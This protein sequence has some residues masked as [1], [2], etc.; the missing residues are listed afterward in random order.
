MDR[1]SVRVM[2]KG[3]GWVMP[4]RPT[5]SD[6]G[7]PDEAEQGESVPRIGAG[8]DKYFEDSD[9][10]VNISD[11]SDDDDDDEASNK[12]KKERA[13]RDKTELHAARLNN[14]GIDL[15]HDDD[16]VI[17]RGDGTS[18]TRAE[19]DAAFSKKR[20]DDVTMDKFGMGGYFTREGQ[21]KENE[22]EEEDGQGDAWLQALDEKGALALAQVKTPQVE[23]EET[24]ADPVAGR[25][26]I[27][28][29]LKPRETVLAALRRLGPKKKV[30]AWQLKQNTRQQRKK[31]KQ[32][33]EKDISHQQAK[34]R[35]VHEEEDEAKPSEK[36]ELDEAQKA[37]EAAEVAK[38]KQLFDALTSAAQKLI[39]A[40]HF[41]IYQETRERME[42]MMDREIDRR[43]EAAAARKGR[44]DKAKEQ[45]E[46]QWLY[47]W[48]EED[49]QVHGPFNGT[50]MADW[51]S[52]GYFNKKVV[53]KCVGDQT[54]WLPASSV[55]SFVDRPD[56][57]IGT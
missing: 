22:T 46:I 5:S 38:N 26:A 17:Q 9:D 52:D 53:V 19:I 47:R 11:D 4:K 29:M 25:A 8:L 44:Q 54:P 12:M 13:D 56:T 6:M 20:N 10:E 37:A 41:N 24:E 48:T 36:G 1:K 3:K 42:L 49:R 39:E 2:G 40:G 18:R 43:E 7:D 57:S 51:A 28:R 27:M 55:E 23:A 16:V 31:K 30:P 45:G 32:K 15:N 35:R 33:E 34:R 14:Q 21:F 50:E